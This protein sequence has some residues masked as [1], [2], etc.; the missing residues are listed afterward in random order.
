MLCRRAVFERVGLFDEA[1]E[2]AEDVEWLARMKEFEIPTS[3]IEDIALEYRIHGGN[4]TL[5]VER[6][7]SFLLRALKQTLDRR[8][9]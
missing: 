7:Q 4:M 1:L 8:R 5:D 6:N 9:G 3:M 2:H